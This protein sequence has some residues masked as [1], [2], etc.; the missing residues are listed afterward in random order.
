LNG[1]GPGIY[2]I[3]HLGNQLDRVFLPEMNE[4]FGF[5]KANE[6][7]FTNLES[8]AKI[9]LVM[10]SSQDY[11]G[12]M[13]LLIEEHI[14]YDLIQPHAL[15]SAD[16]PR[17]LDSYDALILSNVNELSGD[18][19]SLIDQ[20]VQNGG[21]LLT[22]GFPGIYNGEGMKIPIDT[23]RLRCLGI[24]PQYQ[25]FPKTR[26]TYL[27]VEEKDKPDLGKEEFRD[28]D[29]ILMNSDF[30]K[31]QAREDAESYMKLVPNTMHG[32]PE[33]CYFTDTDVS[34]FP[35]VIVNQYGEGKSV[36]IPWLL[37]SQYNW[38]GNNAHRALFLVSLK[39]LLNIKDSFITD[40]SPL[41]E[42]THLGNREEAFEWIGM[43]NHSGQIGNVFRAPVPVY[44]ITIR[45]KPLKPVRSIHLVRNGKPLKYKQ[46]DEWIECTVP[47]VDDYEMI[48]CQYI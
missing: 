5:H 11:R 19:I 20:Y 39:N 47:G 7:L 13:R 22:T 38:R 29:A 36:Y 24:M 14:P 18:K 30:L 3:G 43:I 46:V 8:R 40:A 44:N 23:I 4:I 41:I 35:G 6:T 42:M 2:F 9:C 1:A 15:G 31:C 17:K 10:G 27:K 25:V 34:E 21:R 37:G 45:F 32:P 16:M 28:F 12:I 26:S 33:K 48:L